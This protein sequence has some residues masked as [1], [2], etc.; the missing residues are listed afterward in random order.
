MID[1]TPMANLAVLAIAGCIAIAGLLVA[2]IFYSVQ[3]WSVLPATAVVY[4][5]LVNIK[6]GGEFALPARPV[7]SLAAFAHQII[8]HR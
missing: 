6:S 4:G 2:S 8:G 1:F 3:L 5:A 7:K